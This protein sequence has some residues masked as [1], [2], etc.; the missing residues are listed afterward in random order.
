MLVNAYATVVQRL[1]PP[2]PFTARG[3]VGQDGERDLEMAQHLDGFS[4]W[5]W[6]ACGEQMTAHVWSLLQHLDGVHWHHTFTA[7]DSD[8]AA[9]G[10]WARR[11]NAILVIAPDDASISG[12]ITPRIAD[13]DFRPLLPGADGTEPTGRAPV[14][15]E[16]V[17]RARRVRAELAARGIPVA[18]T[19]PP[20]R[21][22]AELLA[23]RPADVA[24]RIVALGLTVW[25]AHQVAQGEPPAP[26]DPIDVLGGR[27]L[28]A[29]ERE[30]FEGAGPEVAGPLTW[31]AEAQR[32]LLWAAGLEQLPWPDEPQ[33]TS[34]V[35]DT[36][37]ADGADGFVESLRLRPVEQLVDEQERTRALLW[38]IRQQRIEGRPG[39]G[40]S[41]DVVEERMHALNWLL[42]RFADWDEVDTAT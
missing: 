35:L 25:R 30:L 17:D 8:R 27:W 1:D 4:G 2:M 23:Q 34:E 16:S 15:P 24:R 33:P 5:I 28:S 21:S 18:E 13:P 22:A 37:L 40:V 29:A 36:A 3:L 42:D 19:L 31:R 20:V 9:V 41:G 26:L 14:L 38:S 7:A 39:S 6:H 10:D 12:P 11:V 32:T